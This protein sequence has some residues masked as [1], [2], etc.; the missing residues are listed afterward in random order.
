MRQKPQSHDAAVTPLDLAV[1]DEDA[2]EATADQ[3]ARAQ[4]ARAILADATMTLRT[5]RLTWRR[6]PEAPTLTLHGL[7][8]VRNVGPL[9]LRR[10][11]AVPQ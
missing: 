8:V 3:W 7:L 5:H 9:V 2:A 11:F 10:E 1:T 4:E 6:H